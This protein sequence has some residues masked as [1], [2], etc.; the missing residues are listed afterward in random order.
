MTQFKDKSAKIKTANG[1][2]TIPTGILMYPTLMVSD[3]LLYNADIIP[4]GID[5]KQHVELTRNL[6]IRLN[7]KFNTTYKIPEPYIPEVGA[8]IMSLTDPSKKMSKSDTNPKSAIYLLDD[9]EDAYKKILKAVTD[10][11]GKIYLSDE[12]PGIKNLLTIY[13]ALNDISLQ[14]SAEKFKNSNYGE[15]KNAVAQCVKEFLIKI[16]DKY[17]NALNQIETLSQEGAKKASEVAQINLDMLLK[18]IGLR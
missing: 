12:K 2:E 14:E 6:A 15:F 4:V 7:N 3:I 17:K 13:S 8:K 18:G 16:Q 5:Q 1:M 9:P 10:S 11:E